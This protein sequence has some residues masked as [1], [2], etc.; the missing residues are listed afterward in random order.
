[1]DRKIVL[2]LVDLSHGC[3]IAD[4]VVSGQ[5]IA[6]LESALGQSLAEVRGGCYLE[7]DRQDAVKVAGHFAET[8][9]ASCMVHVRAWLGHDDLPYK[10]HTQRELLLMLGGHK[11]MAVFVVDLQYEEN[12][13]LIPERYFAPYVQ[14]GLFVERI[15][16]SEANGVR[17]LTVLYA[18]RDQAWRIDAWLLL[19]KTAEKAGWSEG[20]ERMEGSLLGYEDW[21]NDAHIELMARRRA[22]SG[23]PA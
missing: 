22:S 13:E 23:K 18:V 7:L 6:E 16:E 8:L 10:I 20:F 21:Q 2:E 19:K 9:P 1:M 4:S 11:P 17:L 14:E 3:V 5:A 15:V 12:R